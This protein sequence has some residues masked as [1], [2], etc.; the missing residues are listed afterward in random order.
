MYKTQRKTNKGLLGVLIAC[1][2]VTILYVAACLVYAAMV[3]GAGDP[4]LVDFV[5]VLSYHFR[6]IGEL[7]SF[8]YGDGS[9]G[10]F[11]LSVFIYALPICWIIF[12]VAAVITAESKK[13]RIMWWAITAVFIDLIVYSVFASGM[14]KYTKIIAGEG[15]FAGQTLLLVLAW[16]IIGLGAIHFVLAMLSYFWSIVE[17]FKNPRVLVEEE[18]EGEEEQKEELQEV[19]EEESQAEEEPQAEEEHLEAKKEEAPTP[20]KKAKPKGAYIIQNF[21]NGRRGMTKKA[22]APATRK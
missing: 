8:S 17:S 16:S 13:R 21:Y 1:G 12:L 22:E 2:V 4:D 10:Y 11:S 15:V 7:L 18:K 20:K 9:L 5:A 3:G 14:V 19:L 6:S